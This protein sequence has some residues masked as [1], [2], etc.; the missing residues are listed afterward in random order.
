M[1]AHSIFRFFEINSE[2]LISKC[3]NKMMKALKTKNVIFCYLVGHWL[4]IKNNKIFRS[5]PGVS[6]RVKK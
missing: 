5:A 3:K 4:G 2:T 6:N 1:W